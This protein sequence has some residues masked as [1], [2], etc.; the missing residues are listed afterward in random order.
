MRMQRQQ[1]QRRRRQIQEEEGEEEN[2]DNN[3][4]NH[5]RRK[6]RRRERFHQIKFL[7]IKT[8]YLNNPINYNDYVDNYDDD[9]KKNSTN[10]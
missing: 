1:Q 4:N 7:R 9:V 5:K 10:K 3:N 8:K 2:D 6:Q